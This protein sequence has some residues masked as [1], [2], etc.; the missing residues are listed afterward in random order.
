M[1]T[2]WSQD[3]QFLISMLDDYQ[4]HEYEQVMVSLAQKIPPGRAL[5]RYEDRI[6]YRRARN[7][8]TKFLVDH[9]DDEKIRRGQ[10]LLANVA[11]S[12]LRRRFLDIRMVEGRKEIR[13]RL[14]ATPQSAPDPVQ[15]GPG[16]PAA[17]SEPTAP[18]PPAQQ[19]VTP[20]PAELTEA[21]VRSIVREELSTLQR[22]LERYLTEVVGDLE[23]TML[24]NCRGPRGA[25]M[26]VTK[27]KL[28][29]P[30]DRPDLPHQRPEN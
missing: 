5:R 29:L 15:G 13:L 10:R 7:G 25:D 26:F 30:G 23:Q 22:G 19:P 8:T 21:L 20:A 27:R 11:Y 3:V 1:A 9:S 4:W 2:P 18:T 17:V 28:F 24:S 6:G 16:T 14:G 12:S